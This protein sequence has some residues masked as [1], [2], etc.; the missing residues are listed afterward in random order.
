MTEHREQYKPEQEEGFDI[1]KLLYKVLGRWY[2]F[3]LSVLIAYTVSWL[4]NRYTVPQYSV[5]AS[6]IINEEKKSTAELLVSVL[7]RYSPRKNI[8]NEIAIL[9][10]YTMAAKTLKQLDFDISYYVVGRIRESLMYPNSPFLVIPDS[11][12]VAYGTRVDVTFLP[13]NQCQIAIGENIK[14]TIQVGEKFKYPSFPFTIVLNKNANYDE[15]IGKKFF[16]IINNF[17]S[18][19]NRYRGKVTL[20]SNDKRGTVLT[21]TIS[22]ENSQKE[23]D[24]VNTLMDVYIQNGLEEKNRTSANAIQFIDE[25][26]GFVTDSLKRTEDVMQNFRTSNKSFNFSQEGNIVLDRLTTMQSEKSEVKR[27]LDYYEYLRNYIAD[28]IDLN[29]TVA[30]SVIGIGDPVLNSLVNELTALSTEKMLL[31]H[32]SSSEKNPVIKNMNIQITSILTSLRENLK[33]LIASTNI[34][35]KDVDDRIKQVERELL[36]LPVTERQLL[37][38]QRE[39]NMNNEI[40][41]FLLKKRADAAISKASNVA[42]N[43][44]LDYAVVQNAVKIAPKTKNN[45]MI[46]IALGLLIPLALIFIMDFFNQTVTD[47][48]EI[49]SS[50][51]IPVVGMIGHNNEESEVPVA[52]NPASPLSESFRALRTNLHYILRDKP[53]KI[54]NV[55]STVSGEGKTF[56]SVNLAAM[57]AH[58]GKKVL[59][60]GLDLRK[61]KISRIFNVDNQE[62]I[63]T[64]LIGDSKYDDII[65]LTNINNLYIATS[66]PVPPNP[67]EL[68]ETDEMRKLLEIAG[69]EFDFVIIDTPPVAV[70]VDSL[71]LAQYADV[72]IFV[73]RQHLS[74]KDSLLLANDLQQRPEIKGLSLVVNDVSH[75]S[76]YGFGKYRYSYNYGYGYNYGGYAGYYSEY[77]KED[78]P[79]KPRKRFFSKKNS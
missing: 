4:I 13:D 62:G 44:V 52:E 22:G 35:L 23:V 48:Q 63:S 60:M 57:I 67:A 3:I 76:A 2:W 56:I 69:A 9:K 66:G 71:L 77:M 50:T 58:S 21:L 14:E 61:P 49:K 20:T 65:R 29:K 10:S 27:Q 43:K 72:N 55:T 53:G 74:S 38:I 47:L 36:K 79:K 46:A 37:N 15:L 41:N 1:K 19:V 12:V 30:P 68:I 26:L 16:F 31:S 24:Y 54:I 34:A 45:R 33:Q 6:L 78:Q 18:L 70:V 42:D 28:E 8:E 7:D 51:T 40:Y 11:S 32:S 5:N 39:Y 59:L 73:V 25:Q 64:Y 75:N 17:N